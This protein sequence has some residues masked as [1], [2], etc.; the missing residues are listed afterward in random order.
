MAQAKCWFTFET[1]VGAGET[2]PKHA[3]PCTEIVHVGE[4]RG[5]LFDGDKQFHY[6]PGVLLI[7]QA[8]G[9]HWVE[10]QCGGN[11]I[12]LGITGCGAECLAV[13]VIPA[14]GV[15]GP[16]FQRLRDVSKGGAARQRTH[17]DLLAGLIAVELLADS[18]PGVPKPS[19]PAA[20]AR[21]LIDTRFHE[22]LCLDEIASSVYI[23]PDYLRQVFRKEFGRSPI[24][25]L[26]RRRIEAACEMLLHTALPIQDISRGCG[27]E[28]PFYF[29][30]AFR[31]HMGTTPSA[32]RR[33]QS[34]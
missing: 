27:F 4:S 13:G 34:P 16:L 28:N 6:Q 1:E 19:G 33:A 3:H 8:G 14:P 32:Y 2:C 11:H 5:E 24:H 7:Y 22:P 18:S 26:I 31:K 15:I 30:R 21:E 12:C 29:S 23:S 10:N 25:Y 9:R 17:L 20:A